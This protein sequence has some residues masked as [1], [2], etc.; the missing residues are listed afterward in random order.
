MAK[1]MSTERIREMYPDQWVLIG[2][3]VYVDENKLEMLSGVPLYHSPD[4]TEVRYL[5]K[6]KTAGF[7]KITLIHTGK[8]RRHSP[9]SVI[10]S[11]YGPVN[12]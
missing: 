4:K 2:N 6:E 8:S 5:G 12:S 3:P 1:S 11:I 9:S 7:H 10:A